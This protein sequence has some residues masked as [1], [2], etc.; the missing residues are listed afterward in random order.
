MTNSL[1]KLHYAI[2]LIL[3]IG[4]LCLSCESQPDKYLLSGEGI[5]LS[6][7]Y[8]EAQVEQRSPSPMS[9]ETTIHNATFFLYDDHDNLITSHYTENPNAPISLNIRHGQSASLYVVANVG[10]WTDKLLA[11]TAAGLK[12]TYWEYKP[13]SFDPNAPLPMAGELSQRI[14]LDQDRHTIPLRRLVAKLR[15]LVD[16]TAL[17]DEVECFEIKQ[18]QLRNL[19]KRVQFF[20]ESKALLPLQVA[21]KGMSYTG[22]ALQAIWSTGLDFYLPENCQGDLLE[23]NQDEITHIPPTPYDQ[24]CSFIEFTVNYR[25]KTQVNDHLIYR[26]Y[27]HDGHHLDNFDIRRNTLYTCWTC[28]SGD[29]INEISWRIDTS[30][31]QYRVAKI[32]LSPKTHT[33]TALGQTLNIQA[34]VL[35]A[36]AANPKLTWSSSDEAVASVTANGRV[37]ANKNGNCIIT[38]TSTDGSH[39]SDQVHITVNENIAPSSITISPSFANILWKGTFKLTASILP[40]N[41]TD[42]RVTWSTSNNKIAYVDQNGVVTGTGIGTCKIIATTGNQ[43]CSDT[44]NVEVSQE[45]F[46]MDPIPTLYPNYNVPWRITHTATPSGTPI[47]TIAKVSQGNNLAKISKNIILVDLP[48][49]WIYN[50]AEEIIGSFLLSGSLNGI[51]RYQDVQISLGKIQFNK[52]SHTFCLGVPE[53]LTPD[54]RIP[55]DIP[56]QWHSLDTSVVRFDNEGYFYPLKTGTSRAIVQTDTGAQTQLE[57]K[58]IA[59]S[60]TI[61]N[62]NEL[63]LYENERI[64]LS[65]FSSPIK[66]SGLA[67]RWQIIQGAEYISLDADGTLTGMRRSGSNPVQVRIYYDDFPYIYDDIH[68][69]VRPCVSATLP[70][71]QLLNTSLFPSA[72]AIKA[73]PSRITVNYEVAPNT[74]IHWK[75]FDAAGNESNDLSINAEGILSCQNIQASGSYTIYGYDDTG[76]YQTAALPVRVYRYLEYEIGLSA[77]KS[78]VNYGSDDA[79]SHQITYTYTMDSKWHANAWN[80]LCN[81]NYGNRRRS[82]VFASLRILHFPEERKSYTPIVSSGNENRPFIF[83]QDYV[84]N[85]SYNP[86]FTVWDD[87]TAES[88]LHHPQNNISQ[89]GINGMAIELAQGEYYYIRQSSVEFYNQTT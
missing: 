76:T 81:S 3:L 9:Q 42:K 52:T 29:G 33:F 7:Q 83:I 2:G 54:Y 5:S 37:T 18:I 40:E 65:F 58:V 87:L 22:D 32:E 70:T 34:N 72:K 50:P 10:D 11:I 67:T 28:F 13:D 89:A 20:S 85:L 48:E 4:G 69:T 31:M 73:Y 71:D 60:L 15:I 27:L 45:T 68:I 17:S 16:T 78:Q 51:V 38:A 47:Y 30:G 62:G 64:K 23:S 57:F 24:L 19:N 14:F 43:Q 80:W 46:Q 53:R 1:H 41:A 39:I 26:Y 6:F 59:P 84:V 36:S 44:I 75:I 49:N 88:Y 25:S 35:P 12:R 74:Q 86:Q 63:S 8:L 56:Y 79:N 55:E 82:D 21:D 77:W 66:A 61:L